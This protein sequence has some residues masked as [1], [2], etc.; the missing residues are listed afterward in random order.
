MAD[1][2]YPSASTTPQ[3][4]PQRNKSSKN[5]AIGLLAAGL[6]GTW[7]YFLYDKN[8]SG[9]KQQIVQTQSDN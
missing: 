2:N 1:T 4:E 5:L 9:E 6:L 8:Q 3:S 7:G